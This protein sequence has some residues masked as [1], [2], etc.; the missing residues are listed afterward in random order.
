MM[1]ESPGQ[2]PDFVH[3]PFDYLTADL[4]AATPR[5]LV[6]RVVHSSSLTQAVSLQWFKRAVP[7]T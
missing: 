1:P 3:S 4:P 7:A 2:A 5:D 6:R